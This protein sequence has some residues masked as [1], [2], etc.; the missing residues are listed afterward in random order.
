MIGGER[1]TVVEFRV[2]AEPIFRGESACVFEPVSR[3]I[4]L[5]P[6]GDRVV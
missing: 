4:E 6:G 3:A 2:F 5:S 1:W